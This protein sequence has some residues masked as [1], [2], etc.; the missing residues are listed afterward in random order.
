[1]TLTIEELPK[2]RLTQDEWDHIRHLSY[3]DYDPHL[4]PR[5]AVDIG[6][7]SGLVYR[8][9]DGTPTL[10]EVGREALRLMDLLPLA[11]Q[12]QVYWENYSRYLSGLPPL[13]MEMA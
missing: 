7:L 10:T 8:E 12:R 1:M 11:A 9:S 2:L 6:I 3:S 5:S 13:R 4:I